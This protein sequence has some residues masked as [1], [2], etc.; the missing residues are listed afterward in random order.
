MPPRA[1]DAAT[2]R[3]M[4][5]QR[6]SN[7]APELALRRRLHARGVRYRV[8]A[9]IPGLIR[10]RADL[11]FPRLRIAVF[12][13]GCFW[14]GCPQ[15]GTMPKRNTVWWRAKIRANIARDRDT[16]S[17]LS[18]AGWLV[19]RVWEHERADDACA[20]IM[21]VLEANRD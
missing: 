2:C 4:T 10:R 11:L 8:D 5:L 21:E 14:H 17:R 15:H 3:R 20:R 1:S 6:R 18:A 7:T 19:I 12:V 9:Q 16:D 13:D